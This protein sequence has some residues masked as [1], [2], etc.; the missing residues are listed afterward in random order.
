MGRPE[1]IQVSELSQLA[2]VRK[3]SMAQAVEELEKLGY[4][5]RRPDPRDGRARLVFLTARGRQV[6]PV[7]MAAGDRV[8]KRWRELTS[9]AEIESL[10]R[11]L[12]SLLDRLHDHA[13]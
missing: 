5:E 7:A 13:A 8:D 3:Q 1:G 10:R 12:R 6:K 9:S 4:V 2:H 11:A